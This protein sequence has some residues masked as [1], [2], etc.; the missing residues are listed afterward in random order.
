MRTVHTKLEILKNYLE[1]LESLAVAFSGGVDSTFLLKVA[2]DALA[3]RV[4]AVTARSST[5]P[6]REFA[7][8]VVFAEKHRIPH[9]VIVS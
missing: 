3:G 7:A 9:R 2:N 6:E 4:L 1:S 5:Y 8:A